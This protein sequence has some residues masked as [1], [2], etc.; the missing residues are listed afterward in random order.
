MVR[1]CDNGGMTLPDLSGKVA[2]VTGASRGLGAGLAEDFRGRGMRLALCARSAPAL[3]ESE[4][5]LCARVDVA[6]RAAVDAFAAAAA[7]RF[8]TLDLWINNAGVLEPIVP[9]RDLGGEALRHHLDVNLFGVLWGSQ[10]YLRHVA[11][12]DGEGV[13]INVSSGAAWGGYAGWAAYCMGKAAVDRLTETLALE[14]RDRSGLR[15]YAVAPGII[16]TDMQALIRDCDEEVFPEVN[17]FLD[18][19]AADDFNSC[20]FIA[21]R[22]LQIAFDPA[23]E[24]AETTVRLPKEKV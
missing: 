10:A 8:G 2:V 12:R 5:V 13:L 23:A 6:D 24:P 3:E 17:K 22:M 9:V 16:D 15:A 14:E 21:E 20:A 19:K 18:Y 1:R 7:E 11:A 4:D